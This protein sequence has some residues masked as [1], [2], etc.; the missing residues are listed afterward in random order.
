VPYPFSMGTE[1]SKGVKDILREG[2][3]F[4]E[5]MCF[6]GPEGGFSHDE[7]EKAVRHGAEPCSLGPRILRTET[8]ALVLSSII[9]YEAGRWVKVSKTGKRC[10]FFTLGCKVNQY[11]TESL[12]ELFRRR[13]YEIV[14]F[15]S[16][17]MSIA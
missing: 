13:G 17:Q 3:R 12:I 4:S 6:I 14:P 10:A 1:K 7:A 15:D 9:L 8:C 16:E 11:D 2:V 5:V